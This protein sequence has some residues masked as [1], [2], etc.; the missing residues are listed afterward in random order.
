LA[1]T[2]E[3]VPRALQLHLIIDNYPMHKTPLIQCWLQRHLRFHLH[4]TRPAAWLNLVERRVAALTEKQ[5]RLA[6]TAARVN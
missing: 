5:L 4:L 2:N 1:F 3:R 6:C